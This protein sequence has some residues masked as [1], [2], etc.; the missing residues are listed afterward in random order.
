[1]RALQCSF[2]GCELGRPS[3]RTIRDSPA[4][5]YVREYIAGACSGCDVGRVIGWLCGS[6]KLKSRSRFLL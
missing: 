6:K 5:R 4:P 3:E 2:L 1:M